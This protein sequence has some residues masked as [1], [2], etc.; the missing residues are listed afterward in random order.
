MLTVAWSFY[1]EFYGLQPWREYQSRFA[2]AYST[3]L[4]KAVK[5]QKKNEDAVYASPEYK[6]LLA[7]VDAAEKATKSQD[8]ESPNRLRS[9]T[10]SA[11]LWATLSKTRAAKS[12][13][14]SINTKSSPLPTKTPKPPRKKELEDAE[15]GKGTIWKVDWPL[16]R[17]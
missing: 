14:S 10:T 17:R 16:A 3:Y 4:Q 12:A 6:A 5:D 1:V 2:K 8:A 15:T 13:R 7:K 9:W 11:P